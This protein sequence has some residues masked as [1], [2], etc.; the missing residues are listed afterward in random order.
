M[1]LRVT[2][3][4]NGK[5][6]DIIKVINRGPVGDQ[7]E[8]GDFEGGDGERHY[9]WSSI[10]GQSGDVI[11]ARRDGAS[12]LVAKVLNELATRYPKVSDG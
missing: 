11:H 6:I 12:A 7:Y 8:L 9:V 3:D 4:V 1:G 10:N 2:L 5:T